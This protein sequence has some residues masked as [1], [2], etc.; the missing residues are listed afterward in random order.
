M[1]KHR[2]VL[3]TCSL[4][5][6][7]LATA[8][9][10][11]WLSAIVEDGGVPSP[12]APIAEE[13]GP[14]RRQIDWDSLPDAVVAWVEVPGTS[15]D[16]PIVQASPDA[17]NAYLYEDALGQGAYGTP[18]IDCECSLDSPFVMI[19]GHHMSDGSAFADF[20]GFIDGV[21]AREHKQIIV[22]ERTGEIHD[23][24]VVAVDIVNASREKLTIP[25]EEV[26]AVRIASCDLI[27]QETIDAD[28]LWA[29]TTCS[30]QTWNSRTVVYAIE[31][32]MYRISYVNNTE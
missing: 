22:Y 26:F 3:A 28:R 30:Y 24:D 18:F 25:K 7:A 1:R 32:A 8:L 27:L 29:F 5:C 6:I 14:E 17:P 13:D 23:L 15:I 31:R 10:A 19:Y 12:P 11:T 20:A 16:E 2:R 21:Y 4:V 9:L